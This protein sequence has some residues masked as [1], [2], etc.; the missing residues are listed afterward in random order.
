MQGWSL[1]IREKWN[2]GYCTVGTDREC[3]VNLGALAQH[4]H[5]HASH[6]ATGCTMQRSSRKTAR[7]SKLCASRKRREPLTIAAT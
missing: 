5:A 2:C 4:Q 3:V 1:C 7:L 6:R